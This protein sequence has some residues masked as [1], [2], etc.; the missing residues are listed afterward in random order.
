M[1]MINRN[2]VD[3]TGRKKRERRPNYSLQSNKLLRVEKE[4]ILTGEGKVRAERTQKETEKMS[5]QHKKVQFFSDKC[6]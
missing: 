5:D 3:N 1:K 6:G 2:A 4:T